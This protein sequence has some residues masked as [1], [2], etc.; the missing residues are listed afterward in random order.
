MLIILLL[1]HSF[2]LILLS[3]ISRMPT[4]GSF[5]FLLLAPPPF[6]L[7]VEL[8]SSS[9]MAIEADLGAEAKDVVMD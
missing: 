7:R 3:R 5:E 2:Y 8:L 4:L 6:L 1:E 9:L